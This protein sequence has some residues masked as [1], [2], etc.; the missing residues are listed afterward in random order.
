MHAQV[1]HVVKFNVCDNHKNLWRDVTRKLGS[2]QGCQIR[3]G[4][5][6]LNGIK[7][8]KLPPN[9]PIVHKIY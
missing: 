9:I 6:Y 3:R 7:Y 2:K 5:T 1:F 8:T 4:T